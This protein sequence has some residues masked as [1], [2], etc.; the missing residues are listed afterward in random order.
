VAEWPCVFQ[1][2]LGKRHGVAARNSEY[3]IDE[4][5]LDLPSTRD[6]A[7]VNKFWGRTPLESTGKSFSVYWRCCGQNEDVLADAYSKLP[8]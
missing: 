4:I 1:L 6:P 5:A 8:D 3:V 2:L 7:L